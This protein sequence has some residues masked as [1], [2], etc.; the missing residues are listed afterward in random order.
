MATL[1]AIVPATNVPPTLLRATTAVARAASPPEE[2]II[3]D[4]PPTLSAAQARN[5][6]ARR[7][8]GDILV[9]I[10]ADVEIHPDALAR[11]RAAF[12]ADPWLT[13]VFGSYDDAPSCPGRV[14][15]FRNLLH[16]HVHQ[17]GAGPAETFW[18]G[19]GAVR[20]DAFLAAGGFDAQRFP[21]P[22]IEDIELGARLAAAGGRIRLDP[23]IR[24]KH[25][26]TW[27]L[28]SMVWTDFARRGVPWV[29]LQLREGRSSTALNCGW[30]HRLSAGACL[31]GVTSALVGR[32][33]PV[34]ASVLALAALNHSFYSL[35]ARRR[36]RR[37]A[38]LG[39]G[40][41]AL[42]HL[43]AVAAVP[44][45]LAVHARERTGRLRLPAPA[46]GVVVQLPPAVR[47]PVVGS[48]GRPTVVAA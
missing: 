4:D 34:A 1:S 44:A 27:T 29:G 11:V 23:A 24:G 19:L 26:K 18:A 30:R 48:P 16:H 35:L 40:L 38:V 15:A 21:D 2:L 7:A 20:R 33:A 10:D 31:T 41:H 37:E 46:P 17:T 25:L 45:G 42:H 14:S 36:G 9:F 22:S 13:A 47:G 39:I 5:T 28:A 6:G 43:S 12:T 8:H 3:V 32:P